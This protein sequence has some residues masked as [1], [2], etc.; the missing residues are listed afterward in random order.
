MPANMPVQFPLLGLI[1][2][3]WL[4]CL[5][6]HFVLSTDMPESI[7]F[8]RDHHTIAY[9]LKTGPRDVAI[10]FPPGRAVRS[11]VV[12]ISSERMPALLQTLKREAFFFRDPM[13]GPLEILGD[14]PKH[15]EIRVR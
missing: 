13:L 11:Q 6:W 9:V 1:R 14:P 3:P 8:A 4:R 5:L 7:L 2:V 15:F 12:P 10:A